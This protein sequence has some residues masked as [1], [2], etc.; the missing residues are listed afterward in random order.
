MTRLLTSISQFLRLIVKVG[1][2]DRLRPCL[3]PGS[4][5][6]V[7]AGSAINADCAKPA[8]KEVEKLVRAVLPDVGNP[9]MQSC[10]PGLRLAAIGRSLDF[11]LQT[12]RQ[13]LRRRPTE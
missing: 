7:A 9:G 1:D 11:S 5:P 10:Q 2:T 8:A 4:E 6:A 12:A 13:A 3:E